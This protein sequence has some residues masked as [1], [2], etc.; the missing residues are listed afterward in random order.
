[1]KPNNV[2]IFC[3]IRRPAAM[4][5]AGLGVLAAG[6]T[7]TTKIRVAPTANI[8]TA[9][10]TRISLHV[11]LMLDASFCSYTKEFSTG[12]GDTWVYRLGP[13]LQQQSISLC[14]Q[15]F[16]R[17]KVSTNGVAPD[18]VDVLLIP[19]IH[20]CGYARST[21]DELM[22]TLPVQ[23]TMKDPGGRH[24]LWMATPD[25]RA[26]GRD[27]RVFQSLFDDLVNNSYRAFQESP[28]IRRLSG[29]T[30]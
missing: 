10:A 13:R 7:H 19:E 9:V 26:R 18:G 29:K 5:V 1:M 28:E 14:E 23:W 15:T 16:Q 2:F 24:I 25:G 22:F 4:L 20:R 21:T 12:M 3:V 17:V 8:Q 6:C 30:R 11:G 27:K